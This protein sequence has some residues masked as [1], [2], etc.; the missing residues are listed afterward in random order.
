[1][2]LFTVAFALLMGL[3]SAT[4]FMA[5]AEAKLAANGASLNGVSLNGST[6]QGASLNGVSLNGANV[7]ELVPQFDRIDFS[8]MSKSSLAK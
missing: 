8:T 5:S 1:M 7:N 3:L 6:P 4:A 2:K